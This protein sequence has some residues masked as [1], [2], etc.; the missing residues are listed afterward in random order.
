MTQSNGNESTAK[1]IFWSDK[2]YDMVAA[3]LIKKYPRRPYARA[4]KEADL[5][6]SAEELR[7]TIKDALPIERYRHIREPWKIKA[8]LLQAIFRLREQNVLPALPVRAPKKTTT[9]TTYVTWNATEWADFAVKVHALAPQHDFMRSAT[10]GGLT[11]AHVNEAGAAM[12]EGRRRTFASLI[13]VRQNLRT[14]YGKLLKRHGQDY[15]KIDLSAEDIR[16]LESRGETVPKEAHKRPGGG[17]VRWTDAE[18]EALATALVERDPAYLT[19]AA[20]N[21]LAT[22]AIMTA[23]EA[24][25]ADRR[26]SYGSISV[27]KFVKPPLAAALA[28]IKARAEGV[29][30][31]ALPAIPARTYGTDS[32]KIFWNKDEWLAVARE[33]CRLDPHTDYLKPE[34]L[35]GIDGVALQQAQRVLPA[36]RQ[37]P[38]INHPSKFRAYLESAFNR[39]R[40]D[41]RYQAPTTEPVVEAAAPAPAPEP[42][43]HVAPSAPVVAAVAAAAPAPAPVAAVPAANPWEAACRPLVDVLAKELGAGLAAALAPALT[44]AIAAS[45][46]PVIDAAVEKMA[47]KLKPPR[48]FPFLAPQRPAADK[49]QEAQPAPAPGPVAKKVAE[50]VKPVIGVVGPL[51]A[52]Q[53]VLEAAYP[54]IDLRFVEKNGNGNAATALQ[55]CT[56][57]IGMTSFM[58]HPTDGSLRR[59]FGE[60]YCRVTGG[61]SAIKHQIDVWIKTGVI[62]ERRAIP[63]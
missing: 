9:P 49:P 11:L 55:S 1:K 20:L 23:Q 22:S 40:Q 32:N 7:T 47:E 37:R 30:E 16:M 58:N 3:M 59:F 4:T 18:W 27:F 53:R 61:V 39:I 48:D 13:G 41:L 28:R 52:Q 25:P 33:L 24:L 42:V 26:R 63:R 12:P 31:S 6:M 44:Q 46:M 19:D 60:R 36:E 15:L 29:D 54:E 5:V 8:P 45:L 17:Q 62:H 43:V 38:L 21:C 14:A 57:V 10:L 50:V 51:P 2:E 56:R 34:A 35:E